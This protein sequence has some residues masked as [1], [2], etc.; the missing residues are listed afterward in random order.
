MTSDEVIYYIYQNLIIK[1]CLSGSNT[2][3]FDYICVNML[4]QLQLSDSGNVSHIKLI[5]LVL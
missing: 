2:S 5:D 3:N 1:I 4:R